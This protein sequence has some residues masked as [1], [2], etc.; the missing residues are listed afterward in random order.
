MLVGLS[1]G[2]GLTLADIAAKDVDVDDINKAAERIASVWHKTVE[3][4]FET[5]RLLKAAEEKYGKNERTKTQFARALAERGLGQST[6]SK[7]RGIADHFPPIQKEKLKF[8]PA[9]YNLLYEMSNNKNLQPKCKDII[10][11]LENGEEYKDIKTDI[12]VKLSKGGKIKKKGFDPI[13]TLQINWNKIDDTMITKISNFI[14]AMSKD[15]KAAN[16]KVYPAWK[17]YVEEE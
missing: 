11:R 10:K 16:I 12:L 7:L 8:L 5:V 15:N 2:T 3:G 9:S 6:V 14:N 13:F 17:Q 1:K 4:I